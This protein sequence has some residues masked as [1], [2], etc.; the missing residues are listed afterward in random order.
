[1]RKKKENDMDEIISICGLPCNECGAYLA[2]K[3]N[4]DKKRAEVAELWSKEFKAD[5]KPEDINCEGCLSKGDNVF[6]H[7]KVC[8][9]R[10]CGKEKSVENCAHC[11]DYACEKLEQ[12]F[13]MVP[14]AKKRLDGIRSKL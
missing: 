7:T 5:L 10:K 8:E 11:S 2:T 13:E 14:D 9:L 1:M 3:D 12:F 6:N 4:D